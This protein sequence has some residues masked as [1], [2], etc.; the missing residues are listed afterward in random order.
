MSN[1]KAIKN[2]IKSVKN[3]K[4]ITKAMELVSA[5]KM[6]RAVASTLASRLYAEY[7]WEILTSIAKN[8]E[9]IKHPLFNEREK[10]DNKKNI[11]FILITSNRGLCGAYNAQII[12]KAILLLKLD[13]ENINIDFM[14]IGKK[15]DTAMRR[16][17]KNI[18]A[19][20]TDLPDNIS[21]S[22][23]L[24]ISKLAIDE[25]SAFHYDK[26]LVAYTDFISAL[27]QKPN[28]KQ[29]LPISKSS[30]KE[31]LDDIA[32]GRKETEDKT[33]I[34]Q[35]TDYLFEG[36]QDELIGSLAEKITRMQIYQMLLESNASEQSSRMVA[37]KNA[38]E[39]SG[40]MIDDLT[41][42]FNKAR[43]ANITRE[44]SEISA[45]MASVS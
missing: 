7:S 45:G 16:V 26:V 21:I 13:E 10:K 39:A 36:N 5:S 38:S 2:R 29:I 41:L 17:G 42:V 12:K 9:D 34:E 40:E 25:Y 30:L 3:T 33:N 8:T 20:F 1:S 23:I 15:G 18:I 4:K 14:A 31:F 35:K 11:L 24:P 44:I 27:T 28:I 19:S 22:N 37:M 32:G 43:Q 6:K